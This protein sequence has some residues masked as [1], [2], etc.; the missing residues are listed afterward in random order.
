MRAFGVFAVFVLAV[1]WRRNS[2]F[3]TAAAG[4][5]VLFWSAYLVW[6]GGDWMP[7]YRHLTV[8]LVF[9]AVMLQSLR[10]RA[11]LLVGAVLLAGSSL[12]SLRLEPADRAVNSR[13][14]LRRCAAGASLLDEMFVAYDPL[15]AVEPIGCPSRFTDMRM[16]DMLGLFEKHI[17]SVPPIGRPVSWSEW[18]RARNSG[19]DAA[20]GRSDVFIPGHGAGD[21]PYVWS[22]EPDLLLLC[23]PSNPTGEGCFRSWA[24]MRHEFDVESR[25][26]LLAFDI[27][28]SSLWRVWVRWDSGPLGVQ[29]SGEQV[30]V[31]AWLLADGAGAEI[32]AFNSRPAAVLRAGAATVFPPAE[33]PA[34]AWRVHGLGA[35]LRIRG[36]GCA[37]VSGETIV[38]D[39]ACDLSVLALVNP[40][41]SDVRFET[42]TLE[43][44]ER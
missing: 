41:S 44:T 31:P 36:Q 22:L 12:V 29:R 39:G 24:E 8:V 38:V 13:E 6:V 42:V 21:G 27:R 9:L 40:T 30:T 23:D 25:Y 2:G 14:W 10:S 33:L 20:V 1:A 28:D 5:L 4:V 18:Q 16:L 43:R 26:R 11:L 7:A 34:G 15:L 19:T 35:G 17:A 32:R 37:T 3:T